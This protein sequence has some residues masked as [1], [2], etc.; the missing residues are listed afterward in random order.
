MAK[1][2]IL[3]DDFIYV[4]MAI[5]SSPSALI[6]NKK[7]MSEYAEELGWVLDAQK[8][9]DEE[10]NVKYQVLIKPKKEKVSPSDLS[11]KHD[12]I[13]GFLQD[14]INDTYAGY[15]L[16][17]VPDY[18]DKI[19]HTVG[20]FKDK[21]KGEFVG[22]QIYAVGS[23]L[24]LFFDASK[25]LILENEH[26]KLAKKIFFISMNDWYDKEHEILDKRFGKSED[27]E[28]AKL[29]TEYLEEAGIKKREVRKIKR[30]N[31]G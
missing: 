12:L 25:G 7:R 20:K 21:A 28:R 17:Q 5:F 3:D 13:V 10:G 30:F 4:N 14:L 1:G 19:T 8:T 23:A 22:M 27:R 31:F 11:E 2:N 24:E 18:L 6:K 26:P 29:I 15:T 9:T 16:E